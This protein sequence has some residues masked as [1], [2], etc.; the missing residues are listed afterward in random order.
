MVSGMNNLSNRSD[1]AVGIELSEK[2]SLAIMGFF[3][4]TGLLSVVAAVFTNTV[5]MSNGLRSFW[6]VICIVTFG[7]TVLGVTLFFL[8]YKPGRPGRT[9]TK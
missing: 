6:L 9:D 5:P 4:T 8:S 3:V 2:H 7:L 1:S